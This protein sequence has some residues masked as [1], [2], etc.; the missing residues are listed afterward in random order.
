MN[1]YESI[2]SNLNEAYEV[3]NI[4]SKLLQGVK[5]FDSMLRDIRNKYI[6]KDVITAAHKLRSA[7]VD[8]KIKDDKVNN[9]LF[10][11]QAN[12]D[13]VLPAIITVPYSKAF[14]DDKVYLYSPLHF[15]SEGYSPEYTA[16]SVG[17]EWLNVYGSPIGEG[18][19]IDLSPIGFESQLDYLPEEGPQRD[20]FIDRTLEVL[21]NKYGIA[22]IYKDIC[23]DLAKDILE[24]SSAMGEARK[25][26][27]ADKQRYVANALD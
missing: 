5:D 7:V 4:N 9:P 16:P 18:N 11:S 24:K 1:L 17:D 8:G 22:R 23:K 14:V 21:N 15:S 25:Q 3:G 19:V 26:D 27:I 6:T 2:K 12:E 20:D 13:G 10:S